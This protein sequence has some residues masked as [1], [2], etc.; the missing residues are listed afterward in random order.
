MEEFKLGDQVVIKIS[1]VS[2]KIVAKWEK[3]HGETQFN[4]Q[5]VDEMKGVCEIWL[6]P[7]DI[8]IKPSA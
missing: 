7:E 4:V 6:M 3:L 5:Y 1:G 2:G 8:D